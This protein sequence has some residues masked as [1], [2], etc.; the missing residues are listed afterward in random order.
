MPRRKNSSQKK[1]QENVRARH[2]IER[3]IS[4][5]P[6]PE[7]KATI[8]RIPAELEKSIEDIKDPYRSDNRA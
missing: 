1:E 8:I 5:W 7:F 4:N 2:L 6:D 3:D